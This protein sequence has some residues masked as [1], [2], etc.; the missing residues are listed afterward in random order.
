MDLKILAL[1]FSS[2]NFFVVIFGMWNDDLLQIE[3]E[4]GLM[5]N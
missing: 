3:W 2:K 5:G 4:I 1:I